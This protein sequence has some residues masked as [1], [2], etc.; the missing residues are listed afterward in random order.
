M[1][2]TQRLTVLCDGLGLIASI[3]VD[4]EFTIIPFTITPTTGRAKGRDALAKVIVT[5]FWMYH[6]CRFCLQR[7]EKKVIKQGKKGK[8]HLQ[9][10]KKTAGLLRGAVSGL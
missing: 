6:F 3:A 2:S 4:I 8:S 5:E 10:I 9:A 1:S 7:Y